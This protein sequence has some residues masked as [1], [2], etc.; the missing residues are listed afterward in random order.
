MMKYLK[1]HI[2]EVVISI[3]FIVVGIIIEVL[4]NNSK[5]D[6]DEFAIIVGLCSFV[7]L[8]ANRYYQNKKT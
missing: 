1:E 5:W 8:F 6:I 2:I 7:N 3:I 4:V